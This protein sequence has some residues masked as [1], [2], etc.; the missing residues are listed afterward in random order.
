LIPGCQFVM[1][2]GV[3][4]AGRSMSARTIASFYID[5]Y[6]VPGC[7]WTDIRRWAVTHGYTDLAEGQDGAR[8][9]GGAAAS[10]HPVVRVSWYDCVKWCNARSE[11]EHLVPV[12]YVNSMQ[13][14][15]Y[16]TGMLDLLET[17]VDWTANGYRLPTEAEWE[18]AARGGVSGQLFPWGDKLDHTRANYWNS[19]TTNRNGT[20]PIGHFNGR[21]SEREGAKQVISDDNGFGLHDVAGNVYEWCWDW[22]GPYTTTNA[23]GP[24]A[25]S[26]RVMR[27]GCWASVVDMNLSCGYRN[28]MRPAQGSP[29]I[30]FRC[31]RR[32]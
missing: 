13:K 14:N 24:A 28:A 17:S 32:N 19:G 21:T 10:D 27:G 29:H 6:E 2:S 22:F 23:C 1:G 26:F 4:A 25:G 5:A 7:V 8:S 12:Y 11:K 3:L 16:R 20:T 31:V 15:V 30:G 9:E 18:R